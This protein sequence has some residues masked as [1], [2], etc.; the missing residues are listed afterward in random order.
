MQPCDTWGGS[1]GEQDTPNSAFYFVQLALHRTGN[2]KTKLEIVT[3]APPLP[4]D[5]LFSPAERISI[6]RTCSEYSRCLATV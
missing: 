6:S 3:S 1:G 2:K 5:P 4:P